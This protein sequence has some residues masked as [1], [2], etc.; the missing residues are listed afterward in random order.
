MNIHEYDLKKLFLDLQPFSF[1][2][3]DIRFSDSYI[4]HIS[5]DK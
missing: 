4:P 1:R 5:F 3:E 2:M